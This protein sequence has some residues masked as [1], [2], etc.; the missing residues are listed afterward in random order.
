MSNFKIGDK[1][2]CVREHSRGWVTKGK[3]Y[4]IDGF[5]CCPNCNQA[6]VFLKGHNEIRPMK[7]RCCQISVG[8]VRQFFAASLFEKPISLSACIEYKLKVS[9]PELVELK[10]LQ[11]Q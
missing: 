4:I 5:S 10:E 9:I 7:L 8:C 3:E 6:L 11:N 1:V 2:I